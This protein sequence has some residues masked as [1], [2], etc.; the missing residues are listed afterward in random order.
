MNRARQLWHY[1]TK[2]FD[3]P[4]RARAVRTDRPEAQI[5]TPPLTAS[6][7]LAALLRLPSLL[8]LQA[9]TQRKGWQRLTDWRQ[10]I[11]D[12]ALAYALERYQLEDLRAVLI[13][14][15]LRL[16]QNKQFERAKIQGLLAV[17]LDANEQFH[18]R[19]RC[20]PQCSQRTV[21]VSGAD[22]VV[23]EVTEYYHR[24]VYATLTGPDFSTVLDLE[25]IRP[26]EAEAQAALRLLGRMR[27]LYG[28][29]F[30]DV[31][32]VDAWYAQ[33]PWLRAVQK[34]GWAVLCVLKQ[35]RFE[36]YQEASALRAQQP[37]EAW[38]VDERDIRAQEVRDL[39][40]TEAGLGPV[41]VVLADE[42][43]EEVQRVAGR[44]VRVPRE[45]HWRW[46]ALPELDDYGVRAIWQLGHRRWGIENEL[47]NVL[48][49]HY[50]LTHCPHH[51]PVAILAWL[52]FL[53]LGFVLFGVFAQVHGKLL[54]LAQTTG[55]EIAAQLD[56]SLE[57]WEELQPLWSG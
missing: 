24:Q 2:V 48:T 9:A 30:F 40:F 57:R 54:G 50:H 4:R 15:N 42:R 31:V 51:H 13:G 14:I 37:T 35:D 55:Q 28:P 34:L 38:V 43:W 19:H 44:T 56:R 6:L 53:V 10:R 16:K 39:T 36:V 41:R 27:R 25:P 18:S 29:R 20:C 21:Q 32:T 33:G 11:S 45:S 47:F 46:L 52:L 8:D 49:Q 7:L 1:L 5:P 12:D 22:G 3:L 23:R 26:G 17:A